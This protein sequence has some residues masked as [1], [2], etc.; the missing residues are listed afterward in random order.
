M[1]TD[2][3]IG[4]AIGGVLLAVLTV[5]AIVVPKHK[6]TTPG[7]VT[8]V[9]PPAQSNPTSSGNSVAPPTPVVAE[10]TAPVTPPI[11]AMGDRSD[12]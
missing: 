7:T 1:R 10:N 12:H 6:K 9:T 8:L 11:T 2:A 5:Y 4:F 3:K